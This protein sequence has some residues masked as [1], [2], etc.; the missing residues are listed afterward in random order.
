MQQTVMTQAVIMHII[1]MLIIELNY[2]RIASMMNMLSYAILNIQEHGIEDIG[3]YSS[4]VLDMFKRAHMMACINEFSEVSN[5]LG[6]ITVELRM[7]KNVS[8]KFF[9]KYEDR[10]PTDI[11]EMIVGMV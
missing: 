8:K 6:E 4:R 10:L 7:F 11:K 5:I 3:K 9:L 1:N 2:G